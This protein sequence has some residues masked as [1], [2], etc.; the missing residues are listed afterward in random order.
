MWPVPDIDVQQATSSLSALRRVFSASLRM[1]QPLSSALVRELAL[2]LCVLSYRTGPMSAI[3]V[4]LRCCNRPFPVLAI[5][6]FQRTRS[7]SAAAP[8]PRTNTMQKSGTRLPIAALSRTERRFQEMSQRVHRDG[9]CRM[10]CARTRRLYGESWALRAVGCTSLGGCPVRTNQ[11]FEADHDLASL[12][13]QTRCQRL[14]VRRF[15]TRHV[16]KR[17]RRRKRLTSLLLFLRERVGSLKNVGAE[18][19]CSVAVALSPSSSNN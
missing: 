4:R 10:S 14:Y 13:R 6:A 8:L 12:G 15:A 3:I 9:T 11:H 17:R 18:L 5:D 19:R 1:A 16:R 7:T 2:H